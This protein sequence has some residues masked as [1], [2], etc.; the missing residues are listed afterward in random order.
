MSGPGIAYSQ[1]VV[2]VAQRIE[3]KLKL[4]KSEFNIHRAESSIAC[5]LL[6][7]LLLH[8][9]LSYC[10]KHIQSTIRLCSVQA[11]TLIGMLDIGDE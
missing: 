5:S 3:E 8:L 7:S 6:S 9:R 4:V 2:E 11:S 10:F 1:L